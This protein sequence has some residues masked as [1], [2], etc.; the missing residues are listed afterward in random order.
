[1][2]RTQHRKFVSVATARSSDADQ[3]A[4]RVTVIFESIKRVG[5]R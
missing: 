5:I 4:R 3:S 2:S 1:M